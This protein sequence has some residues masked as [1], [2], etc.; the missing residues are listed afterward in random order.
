[1]LKKVLKNLI[2]KKHINPLSAFIINLVALIMF[3]L[4]IET[5]FAGVKEVELSADASIQLVG[6]ND[7]PELNLEEWMLDLNYLN[8]LEPQV[9]S[10]PQV[11]IKQR[12]G[13]T[14]G[15]LPIGGSIPYGS[16]PTDSLELNREEE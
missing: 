11:I 9:I 12:R 5:A 2:M 8:Q 1:M 15:H 3:S 6:E 10:I 16:E 7:E 4:V 14:M 13:F